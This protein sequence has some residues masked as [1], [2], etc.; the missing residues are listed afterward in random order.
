MS[1][2][3]TQPR[4]AKLTFKSILS[5]PFRLCNPPPAV[6]KVRSCGVTPVLKVNLDDV[7]ERKH[8]PPLGL[9]DFEASNSR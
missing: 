4:A 1:S 7:L 3:Q 2:T 9:K 6:T 8:L 5:L